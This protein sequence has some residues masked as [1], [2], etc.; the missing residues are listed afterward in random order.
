MQ[1]S[2]TSTN[3]LTYAGSAFFVVIGIIL[4][5]VIQKGITG[6]SFE[7]YLK[8]L[9][10]DVFIASNNTKTENKY[11]IFECDFL[12]RKLVFES[13]SIN[14]LTF[15]YDRINHTSFQPNN[16]RYPYKND[17]NCFYPTY[18]KFHKL[19]HII[20]P[21]RDRA[22]QKAAFSIYM[23]KFLKVQHR[24]FC[25]VYVEQY[26][27]QAFNR[28]KLMNIGAE[29]AIK[30]P[31]YSSFENCFI[32]HDVD[33]LPLTSKNL[34]TCFT[35]QA[36][37]LCDKIDRYSYRT[38]H[39]SGGKFSSGGAV[40]ISE[41][42]FKAIN[43]LPNRFFG[44]GVEDHDMTYRLLNY[45]DWDQKDHEKYKW[46]IDRTLTADGGSKNLLRAS[47]YGYYHQK[48]HTRPLSRPLWNLHYGSDY[49]KFKHF[50]RNGLRKF[51][52][53]KDGLNN[54]RFKLKNPDGYDDF[55]T[56][57]EIRPFLT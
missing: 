55:T 33:L 41:T 8:N 53:D 28:A 43:G 48:S 23:E 38:K 54:L 39:I 20:V 51:F 18:C 31:K 11:N 21:Y 27:K 32:F 57:V 22:K 5:E 15:M 4:I 25:I 14:D 42:Q 16:T 34:Y 29:L 7:K 19:V 26:D 9:K 49:E 44:W 17:K 35:H 37:H 12:Y 1:H 46:Y 10:S 30:N 50:L 36:V 2:S 6:H 52:F 45:R 47:R 24:A 3:Y 13:S 40:S 56:L